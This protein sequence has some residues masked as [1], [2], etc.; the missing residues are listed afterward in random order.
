M[1]CRTFFRR[2]DHRITLIQ[3]ECRR[4]NHTDRLQPVSR[5]EGS[6]A[7]WREDDVQDT[8]HFPTLRTNH[9]T[10]R[11]VDPCWRAKAWG[12][13]AGRARA[14]AEVW[15]EPDG[16]SRGREGA[17]REGSSGGNLGARNIHHER[18]FPGYPAVTRFDD[19][20]RATGWRRAPGGDAADS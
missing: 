11:R 17:T 15:G 13:I 16:C 12:S 9:R 8:P 6:K 10:N 5:P 1:V 3:I 18:N 19:E 7:H 20:N 14:G 2:F 4:K